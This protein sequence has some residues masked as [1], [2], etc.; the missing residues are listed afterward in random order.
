MACIVP[1]HWR[2][3]LVVER[4]FTFLEMTQ[5]L[6][7]SGDGMSPQW[8]LARRSCRATWMC[9]FFCHCCLSLV[10]GSCCPVATAV[11]GVEQLGWVNHLVIMDCPVCAGWGGSCRMAGWVLFVVGLVL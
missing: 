1:H 11:V 9:D 7:R 10:V 6:A 3:L 4:E 2:W 5:N 8:L